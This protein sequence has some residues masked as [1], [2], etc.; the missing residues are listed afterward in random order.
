PRLSCWA[1]AADIDEDEY[2]ITAL[3]EMKGSFTAHEE[4]SCRPCL[5]FRSK[6][7]CHRGESCDYCHLHP[8]KSA[9]RPCKA[10]RRRCKV[11]AEQIASGEKKP[12][13]IE[14]LS[15]HDCRV[16]YI[17]TALK[18]KN[19]EMVEGSSTHL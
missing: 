6:Q 9:L 13:E 18:K 16:A 2:P 8:K 19:K 5:F 12:E 15:L 3:P 7:G 1:E 17:Q 11:L 14:Q 10:V 4:G